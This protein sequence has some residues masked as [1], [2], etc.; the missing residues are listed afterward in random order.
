MDWIVWL[1]IAL[2]VLCAVIGLSATYLN[3]QERKRADAALQRQGIERALAKSKRLRE[4]GPMA[5]RSSPAVPNPHAM[6][7][8]Y[9]APVMTPM[10]RDAAER[11]WNRSPTKIEMV[12]HPP[13]WNILDQRREDRRL[14]EAEERRRR[15]AIVKAG[16]IPLAQPTNAERI[17]ENIRAREERRRD[18][19]GCGAPVPAY[20]ADSGFV[21]FHSASPPKASPAPAYE[22]PAA[23][24]HESSHSSGSSYDGGSSSGGDGGGGGGGD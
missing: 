17:R 6:R 14:R 23:S 8:P 9:R 5:G 2:A 4:G 20:G 10:D 19:N 15:D 22:P 18:A 3:R 13:G 16:G 7:P 24:Q 21:T 1:I 11:E 12:D